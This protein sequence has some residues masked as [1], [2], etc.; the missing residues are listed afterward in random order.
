MVFV[1]LPVPL[2]GWLPLETSPLEEVLLL[3]DDLLVLLPTLM[4]PRIVPPVVLTEL[5]RLLPVLWSEA[6]APPVSVRARRP[7]YMSLRLP[8]LPPMCTGPP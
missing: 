6:N 8:E 1:L 5:E 4:P 7:W 3:V 2:E